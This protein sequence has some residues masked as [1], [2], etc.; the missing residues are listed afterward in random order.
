MSF[1]IKKILRV[2]MLWIIGV[3]LLT[4]NIMLLN[5]YDDSKV[6]SGDI[7]VY[8]KEDY[9]DFLMQIPKQTKG[10]LDQP[11]YQ[12]HKTFLYRNVIKTAR[13]YS[14]LTGEGFVKGKYTAWLKYATYP[15][16]I[17]FIILMSIAAAYQMFPVERKKGLFLLLKSTRNGHTVLYSNRAMALSVYMIAY[18]LICDISELLFISIRHGSFHPFVLIQSSSS[19]RNCPFD[20]TIGQAIFTMIVIHAA[21]AVLCVLLIQMLFSAIK[22]NEISLALYSA[23]FVIE[24]LLSQKILLSSSMNALAALNPFFQSVAL[25]IFG[26]YLNIN[27]CGFPVNQMLAGIV[28]IAALCIAFFITGA[29]SFSYSFQT[30]GESLSEKL[31]RRIRKH[32]ACF[33]RTDRI[34]VFE[35]RKIMIH[36]RKILVLFIFAMIIIGYG[37]RAIRPPVF[38]KSCDAEYH[39]LVNKVQGKVTDKKLDFILSERRKLDKLLDQISTLGDSAEDQAKS[40][41]IE[42]E[43]QRRDGGLAKLE[44]QRDALLEKT[45]REKYFFDE[46]ALTAQFSDI[47]TD[48]M[49]FLISCMA[50]VISISGIESAD[51]GSGMYYLLRTTDAGYAVIRKKKLKVVLF[52]SVIYYLL[53]NIPDFLLY[54]SID[55]GK[56]LMAP[57]SQLTTFCIQLDITELEFFVI[58]AL[59]RFAIFMALTAALFMITN[60]FK[61]TAACGVIG[62]LITVM[63]VLVMK[64]FNTDIVIMMLSVIQR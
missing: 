39:R 55:H 12:D 38:Y 59:I 15:Y 16:Q 30:E 52:T 41:Y 58:L 60:W 46:S 13:D 43:F 54:L 18:S 42:Y 11:A 57:L 14:G 3:F 7:Y 49:I 37:R 26:N 5:E 19:F 35:F 62:T 28:L 33:H 40:Q 8:T 44:A 20:I 9:A 2:K 36:E 45:D 53:W 61:S 63:I 34:T 51:T 17:L 31:I 64:L 50:L 32:L 1:E 29:F 27:V 48:L 47:D 23:F 10:L 4:A 22:R 6:A 21:I 25:T 24:Y 56:N